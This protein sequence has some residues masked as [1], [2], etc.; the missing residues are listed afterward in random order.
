MSYLWKSN[1][2]GFPNRCS[3]KRH[4]RSVTR[5]WEVGWKIYN[6]LSIQTITRR[7]KCPILYWT[8]FSWIAHKET[9]S[10]FIWFCSLS[11][12]NDK[13]IENGLKRKKRYLILSFLNN[14]QKGD[15]LFGIQPLSLSDLNKDK[16]L[17][18]LLVYVRQGPCL[19]LWIGGRQC[20]IVDEGLDAKYIIFY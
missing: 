16:V 8:P 1:Q 6:F 15:I 11:F 17:I 9:Y 12:L 10:N 18:L 4:E 5:K 14:K 7:R 2:G 20:Y 13:R 19:S 3:M